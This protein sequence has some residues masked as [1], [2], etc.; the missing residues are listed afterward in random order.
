MHAVTAPTVASDDVTIWSTRWST[1]AWLWHRSTLP[2][3]RRCGRTPTGG[4]V[5]VTRFPSGA[6]GTIGLQSCHSVWAC[7]ICSS[8]VLSRRA[9]TLQTVIDG[10]HAMAGHRVGFITL[11]LRHQGDEQLSEVWDRVITAWSRVQAGAGWQGVCKRW[12][13]PLVGRGGRVRP[14]IPMVRT[15][16]VTHGRSGWHVHLHVLV[17]FDGGTDP[18]D[19][20]GAISGAIGGRWRQM[21]DAVGGSSSDAHAVDAE[22][23]D[24][25][26][27]STARVGKYLAKAVF[28][29]HGSRGAIHREVAGSDAKRGREGNRTPW[30]ILEDATREGPDSR[31]ARLWAVWEKGSSGRQQMVIATTLLTLFSLRDETDAEA[32][33]ASGQSDIAETWSGLRVADEPQGVPDGERVVYDLPVAG[34]PCELV[35]HVPGGVWRELDRGGR[36]RDLVLDW[37]LERGETARQLGRWD[38]LPEGL[39]RPWHDRPVVGGGEWA[40]WLRVSRQHR[41]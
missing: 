22:L 18:R 12:G 25:Q 38:P 30:Q 31:S 17:F 32:D 14:R 36:L 8:R 2:R 27:D 16:E 3:V 41:R 13:E 19:R 23:V 33:D 37:C 40:R 5:T 35:A 6:V 29:G 20:W 9:E 21:V 11:T 34:G 39:A 15:V 1:R 26:A 7:P 4:A 28:V 10:W 24:N